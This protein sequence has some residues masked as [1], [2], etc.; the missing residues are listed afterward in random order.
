MKKSKIKLLSVAACLALVG[1]ASAAWAYAGT[2]SASA[3][4]GVKV[5]AYA[6]AGTITVTGA[7][8]IS[9][10]LDN[11]NIH[12]ESSDT[13]PTLSAVHNVPTSFKNDNTT[14]VTKTW[15]VVLKPNFYNQICEFDSTTSNLSTV[16]DTTT[17][18]GGKVQIVDMG[19]WTDNTNL[20][21]SL[22]A[23]KLNFKSSVSISSFEDYQELLKKVSSDIVDNAD[24]D[25]QNKEWDSSNFPYTTSMII[26]FK[27]VVGE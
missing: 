16:S 22:N 13:T 17:Y 10:V 1:T 24:Y 20:F 3:S 14:K 5:A 15:R 23:L 4:I 12:F 8:K 21:N 19:T 7:D 27:A 18:G 25:D 2:A 11:N 9:L 6:D 26:E